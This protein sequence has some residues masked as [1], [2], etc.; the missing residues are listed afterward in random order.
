MPSTESCLEYILP[1]FDSQ[2][3]QSGSL[4]PASPA[5]ADQ[6]DCTTSSPGSCHDDR[7]LQTAIR[8]VRDHQQIDLAM[9]R[10]T[11]RKLLTDEDKSDTDAPALPL[12]AVSCSEFNSLVSAVV[13]LHDDEREIFGIKPLEPKTDTDRQDYDNLQKLTLKQ[14]ID[15]CYQ[16]EIIPPDTCKIEIETPDIP[17]AGPA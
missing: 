6:L 8:Q 12:K 5:T 11:F 4:P 7:A 2:R 3:G 13:R 16:E 1:S 14:L 10:L 17:G 9:L 15:L